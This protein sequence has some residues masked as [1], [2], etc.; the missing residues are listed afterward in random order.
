MEFVASKQA[1]ARI[2]LFLCALILIDVQ[3]QIKGNAGEKLF[4]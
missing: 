3:K 2:N 1:C 4:I